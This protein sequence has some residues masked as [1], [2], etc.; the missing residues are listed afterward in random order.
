ML[1]EIIKLN[2][3]LVSN[4]TSQ[5]TQQAASQRAESIQQQ[6]QTVETQIKDLA[7]NATSM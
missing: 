2:K 4:V 5:E 6:L 3:D 7:A 1:D